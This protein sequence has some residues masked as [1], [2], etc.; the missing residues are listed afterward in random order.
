MFMSILSLTVS[1]IVSPPPT[2]LF[3]APFAPLSAAVSGS[4]LGQL[5]GPNSCVDAPT[6][7]TA[8]KATEGMQYAGKRNPQPPTLEAFYRTCS[9]SMYRIQ[10]CCRYGRPL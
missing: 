2:F 8:A 7:T 4:A 3:F 10:S 9:V 5:C 1:F 6:A